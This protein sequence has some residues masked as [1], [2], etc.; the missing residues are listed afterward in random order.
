MKCP[1]C[2]QPG[3]EVAR[4]YSVRPLQGGHAGTIV[5]YCRDCDVELIGED[6]DAE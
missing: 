4:L 3:S 1:S 5:I 6:D 2:G